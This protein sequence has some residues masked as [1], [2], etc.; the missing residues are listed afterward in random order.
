MRAFWNWREVRNQ[1]TD[2]PKKKAFRQPPA[3]RDVRLPVYPNEDKRPK[4]AG[5]VTSPEFAANR[6]I[7]A[8]E[9]KTGFAADI[10]T[11]ALMDCLKTQAQAVNG[12]DLATVEAMLINQATALQTL[13]SRLTE[14]A[15]A[16]THLPNMEAFM[17]LA[18]RAQQQSVNTI[19]VLGELK[20]PT[21]FART[22]NIAHQQQI[23]NGAVACAPAMPVPQNKLLECVPSERLDFGTQGATSGVNPQLEAVEAVNRPEVAR[24][25]SQGGA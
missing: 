11:M 8:T 24:R 9:G 2:E 19:R 10:D 17:R 3:S 5:L 7:G 15:M 12:G 1:M 25:E 21:V 16:A 14:R 13:F 6:V 20:N 22:T 23:N 18:L 4:V